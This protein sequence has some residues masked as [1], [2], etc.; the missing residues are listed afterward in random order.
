VLLFSLVTAALAR[1]S[2]RA[3]LQLRSEP[4]LTVGLVPRFIFWQPTSATVTT[5]YVFRSYQLLFTVHHEGD[6][7]IRNEPCP[8]PTVRFLRDSTRFGT[9]L[10]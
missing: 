4:S 5:V 10:F 6:G 3:H 9:A 2:G 1:P 8:S 7:K